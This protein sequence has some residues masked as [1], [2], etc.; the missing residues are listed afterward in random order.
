ML[1]IKQKSKKARS[2]TTPKKWIPLPKSIRQELRTTCA[3][4]GYSDMK[5]GNKKRLADQYKHMS[6]FYHGRPPNYPSQIELLSE[7]R[8]A[9]CDLYE[10]VD[11]SISRKKDDGNV[12]TKLRLK[13]VL[14][15]DSS[16]VYYSGVDIRV[17]DLEKK[18]ELVL[19]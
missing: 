6:Q 13:E 7:G 19:C 2:P 15:C 3:M 5:C 12:V 16:R 17:V 10:E 11:V 18:I 9:Y 8:V 1:S 14:S 4:R